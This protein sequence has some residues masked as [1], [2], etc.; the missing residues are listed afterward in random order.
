M[1]GQT[2]MIEIEET[3]QP[4]TQQELDRRIDDVASLVFRTVETPHEPAELRPRW[5]SSAELVRRMKPF[6]VMN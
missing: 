1:N 6:L 2:A 3:A 4:L 5:I